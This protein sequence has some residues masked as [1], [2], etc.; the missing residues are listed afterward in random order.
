MVYIW[1][2]NEKYIGEW[3]NGQING[4]GQFITKNKDIFKGLFE[5]NQFKKLNQWIPKPQDIH[6]SIIINDYLQEQQPNKKEEEDVNKQQQQ[7]PN[8]NN[9]L[10]KDLYGTCICKKVIITVKNKIKKT[11]LH[12]IQLIEKIIKVSI[13]YIPYF[14]K[15]I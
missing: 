13:H 7:Q 4:K 6:S 10:E 12:I 2:T 15:M 14:I 8:V 3:K 9:I 11:L 1:N 5:N